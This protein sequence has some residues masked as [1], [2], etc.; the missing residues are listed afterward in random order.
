MCIVLLVAYREHDVVAFCTGKSRHGN[1]SSIVAVI[2]AYRI[3]AVLE[4]GTKQI[5]QA[6]VNSVI[7]VFAVIIVIAVCALGQMVGVN[8]AADPDDKLCVDQSVHSVKS[9]HHVVPGHVQHRHC[10]QIDDAVGIAVDEVTAAVQVIE[11]VVS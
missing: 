9:E 3:T 1:P 8:V 11:C 2:P 10:S 6:A 4:G 7:A 5:T